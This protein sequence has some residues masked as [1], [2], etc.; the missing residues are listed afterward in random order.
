MPVQINGSPLMTDGV[1]ASI[2][3]G[4]CIAAC[5]GYLFVLARPVEKTG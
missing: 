1:P 2:N 4:K 3:G 5:H